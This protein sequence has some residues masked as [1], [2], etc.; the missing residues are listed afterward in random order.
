MVHCLNYYSV[1][2]KGINE[3][4]EKWSTSYTT[5]LGSPS[6]QVRVAR[7]AAVRMIC[8]MSHSSWTVKGLCGGLGLLS[9]AEHS[10]TVTSPGIGAPSPWNKTVV[11]YH[12][13]KS[14]F[15][16]TIIKFCT[17]NWSALHDWATRAPHQ[18]VAAVQLSLAAIHHCSCWT[19]AFYSRGNTWSRRP[20]DT[21][22]VAPPC[23]LLNCSILD[24]TYSETKDDTSCKAK[25]TQHATQE[26]FMGSGHRQGPS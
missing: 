15:K 8:T 12:V 7:D 18:S 11:I 21:V 2:P 14:R 4:A 9:G 1:I 25:N 3:P 16:H 17:A 6:C 19:M 24:C 20:R 23:S 10:S 26:L 5:A 22:S 13:S